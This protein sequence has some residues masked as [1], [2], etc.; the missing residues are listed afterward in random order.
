MNFLGEILGKLHSKTTKNSGVMAPLL[1]CRPC[2]NTAKKLKK[3]EVKQQ[4]NDG[5]GAYKMQSV[6]PYVQRVRICTYNI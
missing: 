5:P 2:I 6:K 4:N 3:A 1:L